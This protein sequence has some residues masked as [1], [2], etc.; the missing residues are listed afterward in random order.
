MNSKYLILVVG[1]TA[2]MV[3]SSLKLA[4]GE[5]LKTYENPL[6]GFKFQ[7]PTE[8]T[9]LVGTGSGGLTFEL[10]R[11]VLHMKLIC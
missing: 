10:Y 4:Y 2:A 11:L 7:Y 1:L 5:P 6:F 9:K 8:W 3:L